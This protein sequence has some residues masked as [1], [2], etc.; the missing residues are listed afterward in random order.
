MDDSSQFPKYSLT[1]HHSAIVLTISCKSLFQLGCAKDHPQL[2]QLTYAYIHMLT[3]V[4]IDTLRAPP[5][6]EGFSL[7]SVRTRP[8]ETEDRSAQPVD[9]SKRPSP[10]TAETDQR[11]GWTIRSLTRS[12][13]SV[14]ELRLSRNTPNVSSNYLRHPKQASVLG[15]CLYTDESSDT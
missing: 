5:R 3:Y 11:H 8:V 14:T 10:E 9:R 4:C 15:S 6:M 7:L 13:C 1:H 2:H 12:S